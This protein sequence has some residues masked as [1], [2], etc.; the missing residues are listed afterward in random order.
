LEDRPDH[1]QNG[2]CRPLHGP[3]GP[4]EVSLTGSIY[5]PWPGGPV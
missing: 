3:R 1:R 5:G 2:G 4:P